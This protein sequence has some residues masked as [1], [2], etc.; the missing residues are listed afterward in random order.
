SKR[1]ITAHLQTPAFTRVELDQ[2][3]PT[4]A[5]DAA[6]AQRACWS[7][8]DASR[9]DVLLATRSCSMGEAAYELRRDHPCKVR[10]VSAMLKPD[11]HLQRGILS[12]ETRRAQTRGSAETCQPLPSA[13]RRVVRRLIAYRFTKDNPA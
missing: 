2:P 4:A 11:L 7:K 1:A 8:A 5:R 10:R 6:Q 9:D 3:R 13:H 12:R